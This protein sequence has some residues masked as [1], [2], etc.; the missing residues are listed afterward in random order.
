MQAAFNRSPR[1]RVRTQTRC[2][3]TESAL[4]PGSAVS[5]HGCAAERGRARVGTAPLCSPEPTLPSSCELG[6]V[7]VNIN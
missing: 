2:Q 6:P 5:R 7:R 3:N 1:S 4:T